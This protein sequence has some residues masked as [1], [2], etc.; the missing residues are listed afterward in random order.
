MRWFPLWVGG[1]CRRYGTRAPWSSERSR[2]SLTTRKSKGRLRVDSEMEAYRHHRPRRRRRCKREW[3]RQREFVTIGAMEQANPRRR[4]SGGA[5]RY[6][7]G[8]YNISSGNP[9]R[10]LFSAE[11]VEPRKAMLG[12][13]NDWGCRAENGDWQHISSRLGKVSV[14]CRTFCNGNALD[15]VRKERCRD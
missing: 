1:T 13:G 6:V 3:S 10:P 4:R 12:V 8:D 11:L 9:K 5:R 7:D 14:D 2:P 15:T